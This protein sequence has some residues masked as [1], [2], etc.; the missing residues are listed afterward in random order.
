[1]SCL[2]DPGMI[3]IVSGSHTLPCVCACRLSLKKPV[4][5]DADIRFAVP[6]ICIRPLPDVV[7]GSGQITA[8]ILFP[9]P[10]GPY[11]RR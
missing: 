8:L 1:M 4:V 5:Y 3:L 7:T 6:A 11:F 9:S 10:F 2:R